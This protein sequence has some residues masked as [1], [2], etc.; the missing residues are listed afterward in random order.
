MGVL[1]CLQQMSECFVHKNHRGQLIVVGILL[2]YRVG[3]DATQYSSCRTPATC[4][5]NACIGSFVTRAIN[6][7]VKS[8]KW[9][10][11]ITTI[12]IT[13]NLFKLYTIL[14][15]TILPQ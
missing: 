2:V 3:S 10:L 13:T 8:Y 14:I 15:T 7:A 5:F 1:L 11:I 12:F 9:L 6:I 4:G